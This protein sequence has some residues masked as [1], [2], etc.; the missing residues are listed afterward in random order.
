[1]TSA[2]TP[3]PPHS[4]SSSAR[5]HK[6]LL[7]D[8]RD[9]RRRTFRRPQRTVQTTLANRTGLGS[10]H[11]GF[12][13]SLSSGFFAVFLLWRFASQWERYPNPLPTLAA[14]IVLLLAAVVT[15]IL[16]NR[17]PDR[18]PTWLFLAVLA[19]G[20]VVVG[21]DLAGYGQGTAAGT[22]PT[23]AAAVGALLAVLVSVRRGREIVAATLVLGA[24]IAA[25]SVTAARY[26]PELMAPAILTIG[27]CVLPPLIGAS[28]VRGFRRIVQRELDLVL[29]QSTISQ[30]SSA[31]GMLASEELARIDL[32]AETLLDDVATGRTAL[33]LSSTKSAAA[34]MLA[35]Q[36]RL[37]LIE[38]RRE[39]WLHHALTES[40]FLGP[41]VNLDDPSGLAGQLSPTQRDALLLAIW[42]LISDTDGAEPTV[43]LV[44]G[45]FGR[46]NGHIIGEML[47]F[48]IKMIIE[49]VP[50]RRV[51][52]ET[53]QAIRVVGPH[54][55]SVRSGHLHVDIECSIDNPAD[56]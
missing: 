30:P 35:T 6:Q 23:A 5:A 38:G 52:P 34:A 48:P 53:W 50:R 51:D 45:P 8:Q 7:D 49:G 14:W 33:P 42:L 55:D 27:L 16:V 54:I 12:G 19:L 39:T 40:E 2:A 44:F 10:R 17:L 56:A 18:M 37:H 21:L 47:R 25:G 26:D 9:E 15:L 46:T 22:Y 3:A 1:M 13:I 29:V 32:D 4:G 41:A 31:V 24:V 36:L 28:V 11:L 43:S 20:E